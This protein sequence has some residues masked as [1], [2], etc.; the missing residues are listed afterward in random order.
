M[1]QVIHAI[2]DRTL[3]AIIEPLVDQPQSIEIGILDL[4]TS[5]LVEI[6][7]DQ[8]D[9]PKIVGK[10]GRTIGAINVIMTNIG[11]KNK[12]R[13]RVVLNENLT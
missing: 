3:K 8:V 6:T 10:A 4:S 9:I 11:S 7:L 2:I 12:T 5:I 1:A 13:I